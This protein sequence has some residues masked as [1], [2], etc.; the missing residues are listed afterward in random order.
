M[1]VTIGAMVLTVHVTVGE[2]NNRS[3]G[4]DSTCG[5]VGEG[6]NR[7]NGSDSTCVTVGEGNNKSNGSDSTYGTVGRVTIGAMVLTVHVGL[8]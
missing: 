6:N 4:S 1:R 7:S 8:R 3:N 2:G 5:T